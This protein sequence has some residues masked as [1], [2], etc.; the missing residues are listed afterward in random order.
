MVLVPRIPTKEMIDEAWAD[1]MGED[2]AAVWKSMIE[3]WLLSQQRK[4]GN[5]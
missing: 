3:T 5:R 1:A 4:L 2:A